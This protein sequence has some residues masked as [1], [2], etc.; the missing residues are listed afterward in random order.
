MVMCKE[1]VENII[2]Y[3]EAELDDKTLEELEKHLH[4]CPECQAFVRT[5]KKMLELTGKL[6]ERTFVTPEIRKKLKELLIS[7]IKYQEN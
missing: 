6:K 7:K 1:V 3:I 4:D 2:G 5:Y